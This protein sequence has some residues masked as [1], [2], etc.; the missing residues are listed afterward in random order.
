MAVATGGWKLMSLIDEF[1][2]KSPGHLPSGRQTR[3]VVLTG[4]GI[5]AESGLPTFRGAGGLWEGQPVEQVATPEAFARN[6]ESVWRFYNL[7]RKAL[8]EVEPNDAHRAL[9]DLERYL[10]EDSFTLITQNVDDLHQRAGSKRVL[11][12]HGELRKVRCTRCRR[13]TER[14]DELGELPTCACGGMLRPHV[15]WFGEIPLYLEEAATALRRANVFLSIGTSGSVYPA[16]AFV[17]AAR[18]AGA[19][20]M[21]SNLEDPPGFAH[22]DVFYRG[23]AATA[24]PQL[25]DVWTSGPK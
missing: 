7:R 10:S 16:A 12:M 1:T 4:A 22:W 15:V 21:W 17:T 3:I 8:K 11:P 14:T 20:T 24:I 2:K 18:E 9:V 23:P 13:I 25:V 6:S 19:V 5:S